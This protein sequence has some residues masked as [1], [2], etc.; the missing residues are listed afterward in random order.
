ME[1]YLCTNWMVAG[2][3]PSTGFDLRAV[4][5]IASHYSDYAMP[6]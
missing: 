1:V 5:A 6:A 2:S 3:I 4:Q